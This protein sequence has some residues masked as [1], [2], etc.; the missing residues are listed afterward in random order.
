LENDWRRL[1]YHLCIIADYNV[2]EYKKKRE[3]K[4]DGSR[5]KNL[6]STCIMCAVLHRFNKKTFMNVVNG[7]IQLCDM[8]HECCPPLSF[9]SHLV[10]KIYTYIFFFISFIEYDKSM[11]APYVRNGKF[12][13]IISLTHSLIDNFYTHLRER[14]W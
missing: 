3:R 5:G 12:I 7:A 6:T 14:E 10:K 4:R 11:C 9:A 2:N 8:F 1:K 13:C